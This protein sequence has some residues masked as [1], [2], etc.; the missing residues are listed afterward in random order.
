MI[1]LQIISP[2]KEKGLGREYEAIPGKCFTCGQDVSHPIKESNY[3]DIGVIVWR[4]DD[5]DVF[6]AVNDEKLA[7][8]TDD[9][10]QNRVFEGTGALYIKVNEDTSKTVLYYYPFH[11]EFKIIGTQKIMFTASDVSESIELDAAAPTKKKK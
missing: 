10:T 9:A 4:L 7:V 5:N 11:Y 6:Q 1:K 3:I 8:V 2:I